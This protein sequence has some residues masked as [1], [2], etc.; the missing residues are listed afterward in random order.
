MGGPE[1]AMAAAGTRPSDIAGLAGQLKEIAD[2]LQT[3]C[4]RAA[5]LDDNETDLLR[6]TNDIDLV[7]SSVKEAVSV[8]AK[9]GFFVQL[10]PTKTTVIRGLPIPQFRACTSDGG[11]LLTIDLIEVCDDAH[12]NWRDLYCGDQRHPEIGFSTGRSSTRIAWKTYKYF[13]V[14]N[15]GRVR[16]LRR[17]QEQWKSLTEEEGTEAVERLKALTEGGNVLMFL[18][19]LM[20]AQ[21]D[22]E[23]SDLLEAVRNTEGYKEKENNR[24]VLAGQLVGGKRVALKLVTSAY[25][26]KWVGRYRISSFPVV[27]FVGNDGAG[28]SSTISYIAGGSLSKMDPLIVSMKR[29]DPYLSVLRPIRNWLTKRAKDNPG[30][31]LSNYAI[32]MPSYWLKEFLDYFDRLLRFGLSLL[33]SRAGLGP[34]LMDRYV[35][36]RLRGE[37]SRDGFR[38]HPLEQFFPMPDAF[39]FFDVPAEISMERKPED[40]HDLSVLYEKRENYLRLMREIDRVNTIDGLSTPDEVYNEAGKYVLL[41][42]QK[43]QDSKT[44]IGSGKWRRANWQPEVTSGERLDP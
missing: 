18:E 4:V 25:I 7:V 35:T 29:K 10:R 30:A 3:M 41:V 11:R 19:R 21:G 17:L 26:K 34:V 39:T 42:C 24:V 2:L 8:F 22:E 14:G 27:A 5:L 13:G 9:F 28:K 33:W 38:L 31:S 32:A 15:L 37:Y 12:N 23:L 44:G 16:Q 1:Q 20:E 40:G 6:N 43:M 36:D